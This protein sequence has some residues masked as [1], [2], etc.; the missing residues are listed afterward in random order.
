[1]KKKWIILFT[2]LFGMSLAAMGSDV[3]RAEEPS[4]RAKIGIKIKS[5]DRTRRAK[6]RDRLKAGDMLRIYV[7]PEKSSHVYVVYTD[8][9]TAT[10]LNMVQQKVQ[11]ST[12]VMP[13]IQEFYEVDG[14]SKIESFTI[15]C[16][17]VALQDVLSLVGSDEVAYNTWSE[18]E[19]SLLE[20]SRIDL[21]QKSEKPF[22]IAGNVRGAG[23]SSGGDAFISNLQIFSGKSILVKKY[24]FRVKK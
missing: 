14:A 24:E 1:M 10:L 15:I 8:R 5:G 16:S 2:F 13:S 4:I 20:K 3:I 18:L 9:K 21:S 17:P 19:K 6:T 12:M 23:G 7:H 22:A 11:S